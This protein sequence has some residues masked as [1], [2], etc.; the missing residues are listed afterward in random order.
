MDGQPDIS[1][2]VAS[3][4][5]LKAAGIDSFVVPQPVKKAEP[6]LTE[7]EEASFQIL[8]AKESSLDFFRDLEWAYNGLGNKAL[9]P[10]D[11]PSGSAWYM[12]EYG[13]SARAEFMKQVMGYFLKKEKEKEDQQALKDDHRKQMRFIETLSEEVKGIS[14]EMVSQISDAEF[15][16]LAKERGLALS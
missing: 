12:L 2:L 4:A 6:T 8:A 13:R 10:E 1:G 11:A 15:L 3:R 7:E 9:K 16:A 5:E 14:Y